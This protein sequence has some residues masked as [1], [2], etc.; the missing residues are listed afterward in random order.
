[1]DNREEQRLLD[2]RNKLLEDLRNNVIEITFNKINGE[3]RVMKA[4]LMPKHMPPSYNQKI[5]E[6]QEEK[7]FHKQNPNT[8][9]VWDIQKGGWRSFRIESVVYCQSLQNYD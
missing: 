2:F 7:N 3:T 1:M 8:I 4:T 9:A 6:Q 5:E